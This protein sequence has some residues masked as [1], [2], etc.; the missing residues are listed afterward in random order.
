MRWF[1]RLRFSFVHTLLYA[2]ANRTN[3]GT[4]ATVTP[5]PYHLGLVYIRRAQI[6]TVGAICEHRYWTHVVSPSG[7]DVGLTSPDM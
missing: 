7:R 1:T 5:N 6:G 3:A 4:T 2:D